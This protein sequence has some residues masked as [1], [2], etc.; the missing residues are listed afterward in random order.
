M[1]TLNLSDLMA[2]WST[3]SFNLNGKIIP[4][5]ET[6]FVYN[7]EGKFIKY[8]GIYYPYNQSLIV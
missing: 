6:T 1:K 5:D 8:N 3:L 2:K 7:D 4:S